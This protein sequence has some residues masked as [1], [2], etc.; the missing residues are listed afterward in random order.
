MDQ[1]QDNQNAQE[2]ITLLFSGGIDSTRTACELAGQYDKVHL[3]SYWNGFGHYKLGRTQTRA[4]EVSRHYPGKFTHSLISIKDMFEPLLMRGIEEDYPKI[5]SGFVWCLSCKLA[6]HA[7]TV[8]YNLQHGVG[9]VA[10]GSS[11]STDEM[12]EQSPFSI[13][14]F[15]EFYAKYGI[16]FFTPVY[17][18]TREE[19]IRKL[20]EAGFKM[21]FPIGDRF[22]GIQPKCRPGELYYLPYLLL[23]IEPDHDR[24]AV[25]DFIESRMEYLQKWIADY[26]AAN[27]VAL[28]KGASA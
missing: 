25:L 7:R 6:M 13:K 17:D 19:S 8:A 16:D 10:D 21:G 3:L 27:S 4:A 1:S 24:Q 28:P 12:V 2:M 18:K 26:C 23:G 14:R 20:R 22:L 5:K 9:A 11:G 15:R